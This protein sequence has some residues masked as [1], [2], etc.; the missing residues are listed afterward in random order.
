MKLFKTG[1]IV[2]G[3]LLFSVSNS[4]AQKKVAL[5]GQK[6]V[7]KQQVAELKALVLSL[8]Q[9]FFSSNQNTDTQNVTGAPGPQGEAGPV[10]PKGSDGAN[11]TVDFKNTCHTVVEQSQAVKNGA[12]IN[13]TFK[14]CQANYE[15]MLT[16]GFG[17]YKTTKPSSGTE[18]TEKVKTATIAE[19][20][21]LLDLATG[22]PYGVDFSVNPS[23][24]SSYFSIL[25]QALCCPSSN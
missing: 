16:Y 25:A 7:L 18:T 24:S 1:L 9:S 21:L 8:Q 2:F 20:E 10:G 22:L 17:V 23:G 6:A 4:Y 15:T 11:G 14:P 19:M 13:W 5:P 12:I 3:I